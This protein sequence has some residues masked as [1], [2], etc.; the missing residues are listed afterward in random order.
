MPISAKLVSTFDFLALRATKIA[1]FLHFPTTTLLS[2]ANLMLFLCNFC[3]LRHTNVNLNLQAVVLKCDKKLFSYDIAVGG[4]MD[5]EHP[6]HYRQPQF[7]MC[8]IFSSAIQYKSVIMI[9]FTQSNADIPMFY[10]LIVLLYQYLKI[11]SIT[12]YS[13]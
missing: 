1:T 4:T 12:Q 3:K 11:Y 10:F 13:T 6:G 9:S 2:L 7:N 8:I 5:L